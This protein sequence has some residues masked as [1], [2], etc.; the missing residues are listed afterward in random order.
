[1]TVS[2]LLRVP[3][4]IRGLQ[5]FLDQTSRQGVDVALQR[6]D[7]NISRVFTNLFTTMRTEELNRY[8][9]TLRRAVLLL[10][11]RGA[12]AFIQQVSPRSPVTGRG[13]VRSQCSKPSRFWRLSG[14]LLRLFVFANLG[15]GPPGA[16]QNLERSAQVGVSRRRG[17]LAR[18]ACGDQKNV[19]LHDQRIKNGGEPSQTFRKNTV[20]SQ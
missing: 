2:S 11:P 3:L 6:V 7:R 20:G 13:R 10:S 8:R 4:D 17:G 14:R 15:G 19:C 5:G 1:M 16:L 9:D 18:L 12:Y